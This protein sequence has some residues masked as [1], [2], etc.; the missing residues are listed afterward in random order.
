MSSRRGY[1]NSFTSGVRPSGA[2]AAKVVSVDN[3]RHLSA[4]VPR[5]GGQNVYKEVYYA[6]AAPSIGEDIWVTFVEDNPGQLLAITGPP[7]TSDIEQDI[8]D[9]QSDVG[10]VSSDLSDLSATVD[11]VDDQVQV[12]KSDI[13][14]LQSRSSTNAD[15]IDSLESDVSTLQSQYSSIQSDVY[16]LIDLTTLFMIN[17]SSSFTLAAGDD[18]GIMYIMTTSATVFIPTNAEASLPTGTQISFMQDSAGLVQF[19]PKSGVTLKATPGYK[20]RTQYSVATLI[21][22]SSNTWI[23]FGDLAA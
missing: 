19:S 17:K 1:N 23:L 12:N 2:W 20:M 22:Q 15:D 16:A 4:V 5:L 9:L 7:D 6:G 11:N 3:A 10:Q 14:S 18:E 13:L 21:K 8:L